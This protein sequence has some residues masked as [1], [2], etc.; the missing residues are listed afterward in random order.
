MRKIII[1]LTFSVLSLF[2]SD[3]VKAYIGFGGGILNESL[4]HISPIVKTQKKDDSSAFASIKIGY[5]DIRAYA[6]ELSINYI[7][8]RSD[9]FSTD[10]KDRFGADI[11]FVKAFN[12]T[13]FFY[14]F[15]RVGFGAGEMRI[16]Q[17]TP[18][19]RTKT[20]YSSYNLG[21]GV[22]YPLY[23]SFDIELSYEYR[24]MSY[25]SYTENNTSYRPKSHLNQFYIGFNYR[26]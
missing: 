18:I 10:D 13:K 9:I 26:F 22:F 6:I 20:A 23:S 24:Y 25:Q 3:N 19:Q 2:G 5:G 15:A 7:Q 14:P 17:G 21:G 11:M 12:F 4:N 8:N 16:K 1:I